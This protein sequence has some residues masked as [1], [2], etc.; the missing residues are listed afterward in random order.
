[1]DLLSSIKDE[2][3]EYPEEITNFHI[4]TEVKTDKELECI[5]SY[6]ATQNLEKNK[7]DCMVRL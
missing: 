4:Y 7:I 3:Y 5:K 2:D 6:F 1:L